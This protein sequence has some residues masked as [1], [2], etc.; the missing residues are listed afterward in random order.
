MNAERFLQISPIFRQAVELPLVERGAFLES[1]CGGD[2]ALREDVEQLISAHERAGSFIESPAYEDPAMLLSD[3]PTDFVMGQLVNHYSIVAPL[4]RGGMGDVY[5]ARDTTLERSVA[6]KFLPSNVAADADRMRRFTQEAKAAAALNH[7]H[8]GHIYEIGQSGGTHYIAMEY[9]DGETLGEKIHR[10]R[11]PLRKLLKYLTQVAEGLAKAHAAGIMHRD[12]KPD[13][14]MI[15][16]DDYAKILDF[17]LAKLIEPHRVPG[18]EGHSSGETATAILAQYSTPGMIMGTAGYMSPEQAQGKVRE[19]DHRSDIFSFGCILFEAASRQ[20]AFAGKDPLDS[21]HKIVHAPTPQIKSFNSAAPEE[22]QRIVRRCL[23]KEPD[24][25][26]QSIK[27]VA[28]ELDELGQDLKDSAELDHSQSTA[29]SPSSSAGATISSTQ[30][31]LA[32]TTQTE[33]AHT[34]S[35]AEYLVSGIKSHKTSVL[36]GLLG[37][38]ITIAAVLG[39]Y[40]YYSPRPTKP[41]PFQDMKQTKLTFNGKATSAV[42][43][44]DGKQVVYVIDDGGRRSLWLRQVATATE[45]KLRDPENIYYFSLTI[46]PD[47]NFLYYAYGGTTI[48]NRVL[49]RMPVIGGNPTKVVEDI[50]SPVGFSPN[51]KQIAFVRSRLRAAGVRSEQ[52]AAGVRSGQRGGVQQ[53]ESAL[54]VANAD[55][56]EERKLATR[57][58]GPNR[59]G[60]FFTGGVVWSPD[61]KRIA[62]VARATDSAGRFNNVVEVPVEGGAERILTSHRWYR[63]Q[64]IAWLSDGSGLLMTAA[65]KASDLRTHQIWHISYPGGEAKKITNDLNDYQGISLNADSSVLVTILQNQTMDLWVAPNGDAGRATQ[66]KS[67]SSNRDGFDGVRWTPDGKIVFN[68]MAGGNEGIWIMEGD[69]K[70]RKQLSTPEVVDFGHSITTDG[71]YI[72]FTSERTGAPAG[73]RMDIDGSNAKQLAHAGAAGDGWVVYSERQAL[74]KEPIDGGEAVQLN[75]GFMVRCDVSQ[76]G[77]MIACSL[78]E[79]GSPAKLAILPID[80]GLLKVF[81]AKFALPARMRWTPDGRAVTYIGLQDGLADIWSQSIDGGEPKKITNFKADTIFSFD[82]S[83]DNK[84]A[85]SHGTSASDVVL[86]RNA[87]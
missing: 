31:P 15:T 68:S 13:N 8:I 1:A 86:I 48:Q 51:G 26:Y 52:P 78:E 16:R 64:R 35:S 53:G 73:W 57:Q 44:P 11:T 66:F 61:G 29:E 50:G 9:V 63:I 19:L 84:L 43:S 46:S 24:K 30:L 67:V 20:K 27:E 32:R 39:L 22:L 77:K 87:K 76:D 79:P 6:L 82:W 5:L 4:G 56:T 23:A 28:I 85:I 25:R 17:G 12:L 59:F 38:A 37:V 81:D 34:T 65:E 54:I 70:N 62:T 58:G 40:K 75:E 45:V 83:R 80:G 36:L 14:I 33:M 55:G 41:A 2:T 69:G 18:P 72:V 10:E 21:L 60:N 74:W 49:Y 3:K 47:G 42:I 7:P 71:R